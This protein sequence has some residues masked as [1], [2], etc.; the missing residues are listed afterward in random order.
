MKNIPV[1]NN[2][3]I[4]KTM[5]QVFNYSFSL[6]CL[7]LSLHS[8][9]QSISG[10]VIAADTEEPLIG[11]TVRVIGAS[12]GAVSDINGEFVVEAEQ[13]DSL[14]VSYIGYQ[15][16]TLLVSDINQTLFFNLLPSNDLDAV[17]VTALGIQ[18][19]ERAL[20]YNVQQVESADLD[21][22]G[23]GNIV[24]SLVGKVAGVEIKTSSAGIGGESRVVLRGA[25]SIAQNNNALYV[26]DGIPMPNLSINLQNP[27]DRFGGFSASYGGISMLNT[28]DIESISVLTGASSA[29]LYGTRAA[30]GV[31]L[32]NTK[33]G[34]AGKPKVS[35]TN[36]VSTMEPFVT[37][38][39]QNTYGNPVNEF[40]SW[41]EKLSSP[42]GYDPLQFFQDGVNFTSTASLSTGSENNQSYISAGQQTAE[43]IIPNNEFSRYN[44]TANHSTQLVDDRLKLQI[45]ANYIKQ[46]DQNMITQGLYF[47]PIA[48]V[49]L[50]PRG[51]DFDQVK[52][53]ERYNRERNFNTQYWEQAFG[54][55]GLDMQNP[56][57]TTNRNINRNEIDRYIFGGSARFD[58]NDMI[59]VTGR[60]RS[61]YTNMNY[62]QRL[63][64]STNN[65]FTEG[66]PNGFYEAA[67]SE[68]RMT[69]ADAIANYNQAFN[70]LGVDVNLGTSIIDEQFTSPNIKGGVTQVPNSFGLNK[71]TPLTDQTGY[72]DQ[73]QSVFGNV[74]VDYDAMLFLELGGRNDWPSQLYGTTQESFFYP[75]VGL[76]AVISELADIESSALTYLKVR[77]SFS[78]VGNTPP[79]A[80]TIVQY[81][82]QNGT[83]VNTPLIPNP[84]IKP[85]RTE[86]YEVGLDARFFDSKVHL[87][88]T[89][90][91][92]STYNQLFNPEASNTTGRR[93]YQV[94]GGQVDNKGI[95]AM[96]AWDGEITDDLNF[97]SQATFTLNKNEVIDL[98]IDDPISGE[99]RE[100]EQLVIGA[101]TP[102]YRT[103]LKE[104]G[105]IGDV[106]VNRLQR[107]FQGNIYVDP[108]SSSISVDQNNF[109]K[110]GTSLPQYV[111]GWRNKIDYNQFSL[112]M[113]INARYGGVGVSSTQAALDSYGVSQ[114]SVEDREK[115]GV[116]I[117]S[118]KYPAK[119]FYQIVG[120][121]R[122]GAGE[123]YVYDMTN[124]RIGEASL[125]YTS[126][127]PWSDFIRQATIS[128][129]GRNLAMLYNKAPF[130]PEAT[131]SL[132]TFFQGIDYFMQ[133]SLRSF[134]GSINLKF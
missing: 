49:Y 77:G 130:D 16:T 15:P 97:Y 43:G 38:D 105:T 32:V 55:Q 52:Y 3:L 111:A 83:Y 1:A 93:G 10:K 131:S 121:L 50:F 89:G 98:S 13:G 70:K 132:G 34:Q 18:K 35:I 79:R 71:I 107:D 119:D 134:S 128:V 78:E 19:E 30:N 85:E 110:A 115:G 109:Y 27:A 5:N 24:N 116:I 59:N 87:D 21:D 51:E 125:S 86:S 22:G 41:G 117:N 94:N 14:Q 31:I 2:S 81:A 80:A 127:V 90:Y 65:T 54:D 104:G 33:S 112:S 95:E 68:F 103:I 37:P 39:F 133:P 91:Y 67:F 8:Y 46:E 82:V 120:N 101:G 47:N 36:R 23:Q 45:N 122:G 73:T 56:Y 61:D 62:S 29:S 102:K 44:F 99:V 64:A 42:S 106:Y 25:T 92:A 60:V 69:Y 100:N 20:T 72:H 66:S 57:W 53:F 129:N 124:V 12:S 113:L 118:S 96:L 40:N 58:V 4:R 26:V 11:A 28:E 108:F 9:G 126:E 123:F 114:R 48:P 88:L 63:H 75:S 74:T 76:S 7:F 17:V 84:F 6:F